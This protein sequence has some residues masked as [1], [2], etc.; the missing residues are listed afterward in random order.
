MYLICSYTKH[1][2]HLYE[3]IFIRPYFLFSKE[4]KNTKKILPF[5]SHEIMYHIFYFFGTITTIF[6]K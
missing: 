3:N 2:M 4:I 6:L 1:I 5:L